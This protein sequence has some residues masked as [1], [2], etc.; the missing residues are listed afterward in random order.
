[1]KIKVLEVLTALKIGGTEMFVMNY[2]RHIDREQFEIDFL[3]FDDTNLD[4][5]DEVVAAGS[6]VFIAPQGQREGI[7]RWLRETEYVYAILKEH[8]YDVIHCHN[9]AFKG[10]FRGA[11]AGKLAGCAKV[12]THA[13]NVGTPKGTLVDNTVRFFL[14]RLL[15]FFIDYGLTCSDKAGESKYTKKF[16]HSCRYAIIHNAIEVGH[17]R[18]NEQFRSEIRQ[19]LG[20]GNG[21]LMGNVGRQEPQKN[22]AFLLELLKMMLQK[23]QDVFLLIVGGGSLENTLRTKAREMGI[24]KHVA[25]TGVTDRAYMYY[26]AMDV[27]V[28]PSLYEGFPFTAVEAQVNGLRCIMSDNMTPMVNIAGDVCF[29]SLDDDKA[30]WIEKILEYS[31]RRSSAEHVDLVCR[32]YDIRSEVRRLET[33]YQK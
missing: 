22:Q 25:F 12:I 1:M 3:I 23:R 11:L 26:S 21:I 9:C 19:D 13:H 33:I 6:K 5:Y 7:S 2:F 4:Y 32:E 18:Y 31:E 8:N 24:E 29:L 14:K 16:M 30:I 15:C 20:I 10:L 27:Y 28:M 17:Y